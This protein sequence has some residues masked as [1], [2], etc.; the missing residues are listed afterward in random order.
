VLNHIQSKLYFILKPEYK[1]FFFIYPKSLNYKS[2]SKIV[3][4]DTTTTKRNW[5]ERF[6]DILR[7]QLLDLSYVSVTTCSGDTYARIEPS[8]PNLLD[9]LK[10]QKLKIEARTIYELDADIIKVIPINNTNGKAEIDQ[11]ILK[12]HKESEQLAIENWSTFVNTVLDVTKTIL[13][14][15]GAKVE[16]EGITISSPPESSPASRESGK[17]S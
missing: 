1:S 2:I 5:I 17:A 4:E 14:M 3:A 15:S 12:L 11:E 16:T 6:I 9:T 13:A 10:D 7:D 8:S